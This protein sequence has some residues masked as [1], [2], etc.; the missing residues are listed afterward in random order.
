MQTIVFSDRREM[1]ASVLR[2]IYGPNFGNSADEKEEGRTFHEI[3][4][5]L[6]QVDVLGT[7]LRVDTEVC[8]GSKGHSSRMM[9][10]LFSLFKG[11]TFIIQSAQLQSY[12]LVNNL[13]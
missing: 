9:F 12:E 3:T 7:Q 1:R 6:V 2:S 8:P 4:T 11:R 5:S 13:R 10:Q